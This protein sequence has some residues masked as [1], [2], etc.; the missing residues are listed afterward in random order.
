MNEYVISPEL[1]S[2]GLVSAGSNNKETVIKAVKAASFLTGGLLGMGMRAVSS[3]SSSAVTI[4][5]VKD[6][7]K[8]TNCHAAQG[9]TWLSNVAYVEHPRLPGH[10]IQKSMYRDYMIRE[11]MAD[12]AGYIMDNF[13]L[14]RLTIGLVESFS[15]NAQASVPIKEYNPDASISGSLNREYVNNYINT[16][17]TGFFKKKKH[18][19][20]NDYPDVKVAVSSGSQSFEKTEKINISASFNIAVNDVKAL[21]SGQRELTFYISYSV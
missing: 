14:K 20:I 8:Y 12:V 16:T 17:K 6:L 4:G 18:L 1:N 10:L 21:F 11:L 15:G 2:T 3:L 7:K 9:N 5:T 13:T 19:W